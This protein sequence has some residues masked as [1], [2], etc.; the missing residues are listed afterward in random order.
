MIYE[1]GWVCGWENRVDV[2]GYGEES[3][4]RRVK[5]GVFLFFVMIVWWMY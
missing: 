5:K 2:G 3:I 4:G 1:D